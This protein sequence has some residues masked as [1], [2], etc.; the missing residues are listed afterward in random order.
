MLPFSTN[1]HDTSYHG[2]KTPQIIPP[3]NISS[4]L[5]H[6]ILSN[7]SSTGKVVQ[8]WSSYSLREEKS[9]AVVLSRRRCRPGTTPP[10]QPR[11]W[12]RLRWCWR[13]IPWSLRKMHAQ[14]PDKCLN[15]SRKLSFSA[16]A[17]TPA[18]QLP[19]FIQILSQFDSCLC[20]AVLTLS[21]CQ[22]TVLPRDTS[23][24]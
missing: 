7:L 18:P 6:L 9:P 13:R 8:C 23:S 11:R 12:S 19:S 21:G 3:L 20:L 22:P 15:S 17:D 16:A 24:D 1:Q 5:M 2:R 14:L 10:G 4:P